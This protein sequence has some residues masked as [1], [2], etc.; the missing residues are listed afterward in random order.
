MGFLIK[1]MCYNNH[2]SRTGNKMSQLSF[3][4]QVFSALFAI[5]AAIF[6]L[7]ASI[8]VAPD[9]VAAAMKSRGGMDIFGSDLTRVVDALIHQGRLNAYAAGCA[10]CAAVLQ[11]IGIVGRLFS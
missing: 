3:I 7:K 2:C 4:V 9:Q 6:W 8:D 10:A 5:A 11:A 1:S